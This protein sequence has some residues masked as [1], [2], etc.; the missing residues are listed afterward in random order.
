MALQISL[1]TAVEAQTVIGNWQNDSGDGWIDNG[2]S[3]SITNAANTNK[4]Q[5]V[6][7]AVAGYAQSLEINQAGFNQ[8]LEI[9]LA[10]VP[11]GKAAF[12][13]NHLLSFTVTFPPASVSGATAGY[14]QIYNFTLN[15]AGGYNNI[16]WSSFTGN[17]GN[18]PGVGYY[19]SFPGQTITVTWDYS[20][21]LTNSAVTNSGYLQI[22]FT[23][24]N[25]GGA[26]TNIF[27]NNVVLSGATVPTIIVDQF[28]PTNNPYAGTNI[29]AD[30]DI[31]NIYANWFGSAFSNV[32][33]DATMD[34]QGN[35][36]SGSMEIIAVFGTNGGDQ[37]TLMDKGPGFTYAGIN[38][39]ITNGVGLLTFQCDV[40]YAPSSPTW[41]TGG[42]TNFGSLRFGVVPPY[43]PQDF[44][45]TVQVSVT[46]QGWYHVTLPINAA[47]DPNLLSISG[48]IINQDGQSF[49]NLQGT[50][51]LWIDNL[52][53]TYTNITFVP[54]PVVS[55]SPTVPAMRLFAGSSGQYDRQ[56]LATSDQSQSWIGGT[57]PVNYSFTVKNVP[58]TINQTHMFLIPVNSTPNASP[59]GYNGVDYTATNGL[60]LTVGPSGIA[61]VSWKTN[62]PNSNPYS[63]GVI[64]LQITNSTAV[65]KWTLT[66]SG[67]GAG[68]LTAPGGSA[69][70]FVI[71]DPNVATDFA[72]PVVAYFGL[73]GNNSPGTYEDWAAISV[74]GVAGE[75]ENENFTT[76]TSRNLSPIWN[77]MAAVAAD[78]AIVSTNDM[79]A[80]WVHWTLPAQGYS[81]GSS[82]NVPA[83][84]W[85]NP[86][87]YSDYND[88]TQPPF[89]MPQQYG[90]NIWDLLPSDD[91]PTVDGIP[92][93]VPAPNAF[94][95]LST[96]VVNPGG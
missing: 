22:S 80:Y 3:L 6:T 46:N 60:W 32:L 78:V 72:N 63:T 35:T 19:P 70:P 34:A 38:P 48:L 47:I 92:G 29:Y 68:S 17:G 9:D 49:G 87:Y 54:P 26:P 53:F 36:N 24:N 59:Y 1:A 52:E 27:M 20:S 15:S 61:I 21:L 41:V 5:F 96:N 25:G 45:G 64:A 37:F 50:T 18:M 56:E 11:G 31:T 81:I 2:N 40:R 13:S 76:E 66:F 57:Y 93:S 23:S 8:N 69:V 88:N 42:G 28:N 82:T 16:P 67:P 55:I 91:L 75:N 58:T 4:Y 89:G 79:P 62:Q 14:S 77:N 73:Q 65:G 33:W 51:T 30:G 10:S 84:Q 83:A 44:F 12:L 71:T 43:S 74:S 90:P 86:A 95:L 94:F 7:G 39:P 85:I